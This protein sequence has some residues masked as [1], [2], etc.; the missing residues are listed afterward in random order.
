MHDRPT[1]RELLTTIA[2]LLEG[3]ALRATSGL[4]QHQVR[5]A[6]NLCRILDRE[7]EQAG[8]HER[9][10]RTRLSSLLGAG[11]DADLSSLHTR[12]IERL[13]AGADPEFERRAWRALVEG[14]REKLAVN[15][16][17]YDDYD[18]RD[19]VPA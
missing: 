9:E 2:D 17:G 3:E 13:A 15:K 16:P 7:L 19:E 18:Y 8:A 6:G 14:V 11:P 1:A 4:L 12:L 5:V 10:E